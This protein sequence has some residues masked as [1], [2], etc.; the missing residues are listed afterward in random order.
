MSY[1]HPNGQPQG[2][3]QKFTDKLREILI[4]E[5][6]AIN[7]YQ[8]HIANSDISEIN[9]AWSGVEIELGSGNY[10]LSNR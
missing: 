10:T 1:T 5:I 9:D 7:G 8:T 2:T 4:S 6:I 3:A